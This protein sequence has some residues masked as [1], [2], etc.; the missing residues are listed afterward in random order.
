MNLNFDDIFENI[1]RKI[2]ECLSWLEKRIVLA[3]FLFFFISLIVRLILTRYGQILTA[4]SYIYL[5]KSLEITQGNFMPTKCYSIGWSLFMAPFLK[6]FASASIFTNMVYARIISDFVGAAMIFPLALIGRKLTNRRTLVILLTLFTFYS[7]LIFASTVAL[8]EPLFTLFFLFCIYF[9]I[10]CSE[11]EKYLLIAAIFGAFAYYVR[12]NGLFILP[13]IICSFLFLKRTEIFKIK[14]LKYLFYA[15]LLFFLVSSPFLVQRY[16]NFGSAFTY[17]GVNDKMFANTIEEVWDSNI[18][19]PS[20]LEYIQTH[21][22]KDMFSRFFIK[23]FMQIML[24]FFHGVK[25]YE[26]SQIVS[27][28][29]IFFF[30]IGLIKSFKNEKFSPLIISTF[31]FILAL[32]LVYATFG[33]VRYLLVLV[34]STLI[35]SAVGISEVFN[36][37]PKY[38]NLYLTFFLAIFIVFSMITPIGSAF[39][40]PKTQVPDWG[41]WASENIHGKI[42]IPLYGEL[43]LMNLKD[44][45]AA[46]VDMFTLYAP[47]SNLSIAAPGVFKNLTSAMFYYEEINVTHLAVDDSSISR[48]PSFNFL[49]ESYKDPASKAYLKEV[50]SN[51]DNSSSDWKIRIF[52]INW[53]AFNQNFKRETVKNG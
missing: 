27:P 8:T 19:A 6:I 47:K 13:I 40:G 28:L 24:L 5:L 50:F 49:T 22:I 11:N 10:L 32:S 21:S 31:L 45:T 33:N 48:F 46:G 44:T 4:D 16:A 30:L 38:K 23:G 39:L 7:S 29:L 18:H 34:P 1:E 2:D 37:I 17:Y 36:T 42:V 41:I 9:L 14:T 51:Y 43:I 12:P 20:F 52:E 3:T 26:Y 15:I 35:F 53:T 25:S